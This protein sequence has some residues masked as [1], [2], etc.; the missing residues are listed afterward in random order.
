MIGASG[1]RGVGGLEHRASLRF[2]VRVAFCLLGLFG[3]FGLLAPVV[4]A[5]VQVPMP[6][7]EFALPAY[8]F[9]LEAAPVASGA[10]GSVERRP[11]VIG[12]HGCAGA[13]DAKGQLNPIWR[14]YAAYFAAERMHFVVPDSFSPRGVQS[15]CATPSRQRTVHETD[16]REDVFAAIAW[17][18]EQPSVDPS[19]IFVL[20]WSHGGQTALLVADASDSFV[21]AQKI[22]PKAVAAFYPGCDQ[23]LKMWNYQ[24]EAPLLVMIGE[25]DDWTRADTC[26]GL[27]DKVKRGQPGAPFELEIYPG[28]YHGFDGLGPVRTMESVGNTR[29][30][31][32]TVGVNPAAQKASHARL[33]EFVAAQT[34]EPLRLSHEERRK[35]K[36]LPLPLAAPP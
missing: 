10:G 36:P 26:A 5:Q 34:T 14:R 13:L 22:R 25:L 9:K 35:V 31:K 19:H 30:G 28:S 32:A 3:I 17:L 27:R 1:A 12:L 24:L 8:W 29:S 6:Q 4:Q 15:V 33:F 23:S 7:A 21:K 11:V 20:G 2:G 18:A 16:R